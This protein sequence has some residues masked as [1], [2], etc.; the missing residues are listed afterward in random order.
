MPSNTQKAALLQG[1]QKEDPRL[2]ELLK[3]LIDDVTATAE[4]VAA[5]EAK[6]IYCVATRSGVQAIA[7]ATLT[8]V[9]FDV[10]I[11]NRSAMH[12]TATANSRFYVP[13][14][15]LYLIT[16][17]IDWEALPNGYRNIYI[18]RSGTIYLSY[19]LVNAE[20]ASATHSATSN[21]SVFRELNKNDYIELV[22]YQNSGGNMNV[23]QA[24]EFSPILTIMKLA[25][26]AA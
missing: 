21:I 3:L 12:D 11:S 24:S 14:P 9:A 2:Y 16:A 7:T 17:H 22:V 1:I 10:N 6:S 18:R 15:G 26:K 13:V 8:A 4:A 19:D 25:D 5:L 23:L 20:W